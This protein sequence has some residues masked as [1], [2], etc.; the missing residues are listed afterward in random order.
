M[1]IF[2]ALA[3]AAVNA[4]SETVRCWTG[5][6]ESIAE[7]TANAVSVECGKNELCQMTVR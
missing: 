7:F 2:A 5:E 3:F 4:Q 6:G 1:K